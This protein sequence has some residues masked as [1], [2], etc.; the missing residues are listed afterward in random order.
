VNRIST[1]VLCCGLLWLTSC[2][3]TQNETGQDTKTDKTE[4]SEVKK[5]EG[6]KAEQ[7]E[8]SSE[9][10]EKLTPPT[11]DD[12]GNPDELAVI[13]TEYGD[14]VVKFY[15]DV[16]PMHVA[17]FKKLARAGFYDGTKFH[18][19]IPGFVIQGGDPNSKDDD[20]YND[21]TGGPGWN[22]KAEFNQI[23]HAKGILSMA[24]SRDPNSAGSQFFIC[25]SREKTKN[26]D[27]QYTVFGETVKGIEIVEKIGSIA[28]D[29][30]KNAKDPAVEMKSVRIVKPSE[31]GL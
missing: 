18:R 19:V 13:S 5:I 9:S 20:P 12:V 7:P 25:L 29:P 1:L 14:I 4:A 30:R 26:L 21:G 8:K 6:T 15:P 17:N 27:N 10:V 22:I 2:K 23:K 28:R 24:R 31:A 3:A 16:A 11:L